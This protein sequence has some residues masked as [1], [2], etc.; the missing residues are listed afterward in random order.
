VEVPFD[1]APLL[2]L[3]GDQPLPRRPQ[4]LDQ[5]NVAQDE[6]GLRREVP[7]ELLLGGIDRVGRGHRHRELPERCAL[8][9]DVDHVVARRLG[10][11][12]G[13]SRSGAGRRRP[14]A[15]RSPRWRGAAGEHLRH[16]GGRRRRRS[17]TDAA[18]ECRQDLV[19]RGALSVHDTIGE[20]ARTFP[21]RLER[22]C[23]DGA[24]TNERVASWPP[25]SAPTPPTTAAYTTVMNTASRPNTTVLR[26]TTSRS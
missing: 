8:V 3:R 21:R 11:P 1:P 19:G 12:R 24:A 2:V 7:D 6:P 16:P 14:E 22:Q 26:T 18:G 5:P 13:T 15:R 25:I 17:L 23:E 4:L 9:H 10:S 20:Q